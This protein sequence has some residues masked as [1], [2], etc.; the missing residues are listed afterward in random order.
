[1][2]RRG[3]VESSVASSDLVCSPPRPPAALQVAKIKNKI[4]KLTGKVQHRG[5]GHVESGGLGDK[6]VSVLLVSFLSFPSI[7]HPLPPLRPCSAS[8]PQAGLRTPD[9]GQSSPRPHVRRTF[10]SARTPSLF[11]DS[12]PFVSSPHGDLFRPRPTY[13]RSRL[14]FP[15]IRPRLI[16][17]AQSRASSILS[18]CVYYSMLRE[19]F[20]S[21]QTSRGGDG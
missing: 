3:R 14:S 17:P 8:L 12:A 2:S 19:Q 7:H 13:S 18:P 4:L 9:A 16:P 6:A 15:S 10:L 20:A 1:M 21:R 5:H 11:P